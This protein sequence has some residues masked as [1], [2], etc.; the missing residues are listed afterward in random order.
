[1]QNISTLSDSD[2]VKLVREKDKELYVE[3]IKR[4]QKKLLRYASYIMGDEHTGA[5]VVQESFIKA[6]VNLN[7]FDIK[8]KFSSW[9]YRIVHNEAVNMLS[10]HKKQRPMNDEIEHDSRIDLEDEFIKN[11]L[12]ART[13]HCLEQMPMIYKEPLSLYYLDEKSYEDI[14]NILRIPVNTVGTRVNRAKKM[15]KKICQKK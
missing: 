6:F 5:D 13:H 15:M 14:S 2:V 1:M 7:G 11:E 10:K 8:K 9:I 3:I 12:I 4:Y